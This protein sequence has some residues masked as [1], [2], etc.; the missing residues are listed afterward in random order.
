MMIG[1]GL[2]KVSGVGTRMKNHVGVGEIC[3]YRRFE[4]VF[5]GVACSCMFFPGVAVASDFGPLMALLLIPF[6][7]LALV[8]WAVTWLPTT[9]MKTLWLKVV[10]RVF[11]VCLIFAPTYTP[12]GNGRMLSVSLYDFVF[13]ALGG[14]PDY[15]RQAVINVLIASV[16]VSVVVLLI[17]YLNRWKPGHRDDRGEDIG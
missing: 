1:R 3:G 5:A 9:G 14:D 15:A 7:L 17:V 4:V 10:I 6:A 11:G 13:S 2:S 16:V 8:V 12:G